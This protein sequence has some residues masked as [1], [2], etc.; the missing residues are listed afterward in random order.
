L[1]VE[2]D[3]P[4][5]RGER[6]GIELATPQ[7]VDD[8]RGVLRVLARDREPQLRPSTA[9]TPARRRDH[10]GPQTLRAQLALHLVQM[11]HVAFRDDGE[12]RLCFHGLRGDL[13][14]HH[15][16]GPRLRKPESR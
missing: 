10:F 9:P 15:A 5:R 14:R 1:R 8:P 12:L 3:R 11:L 2:I 6:A 16:S 7:A 4:R 13:A